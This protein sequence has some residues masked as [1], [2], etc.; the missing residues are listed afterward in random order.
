MRKVTK[1]LLTVCV[2]A[3]AAGACQD[4]II[5]PAPPAPPP[6]PPTNVVDATVSILGLALI[7]GPGSVNP[8]AVAGDI[9]VSLN[10][11]EGDNTVTAVDL[12]FNGTPVGCATINTN[13][14]PGQGVSLSTAAGADVVECFW[15]TDTFAGVCDGNN[16]PPQFANGTHT[17]GAQITLSDGTKRTASNTQQVTLVN[18]DLLTLVMLPGAQSVVSGGVTYYGGPTDVDGDGTDD[19]SVDYAVC[20]VSFAG[21]TVASL[22]LVG[23]S[24]SGNDVDLGSGPGVADLDS[25]A[26]FV[27]NVDPDDNDRASGN[28]VEDLPGLTNGHDLDTTGQILDS[29]G[30]DVS[31][32]FAS[33]SLT[34]MHHDFTSPDPTAATLT[35]AGA[36]PGALLTWYSAGDFG[37]TG[38]VEAGVGFSFGSGAVV[39]V[40]ECTDADFTDV[41]ASTSFT[42]LFANSPGVSDHTEDDWEVGGDGFAGTDGGGVDCY[43]AEL[44]SLA[45]DLG[46]AF[47]LTTLGS[48]APLQVT[49]YGYDAT[50][51]A[52]SSVMPDPADVT[53]MNP[54]AGTDDYTCVFAAGTG[55]CEVTFDQADPDLA[56]GDPGS[57]I[58]PEAAEDED[59]NALPTAGF[60][61]G[62]E[63]AVDITSLGDGPHTVTVDI[64]DLATAPNS[65]SFD[66]GLN[67]DDTAPTFG[68]LN[69]AP[70]G[71][72]TNAT[73]IVFN[74]GGTIS[75]ANIIDSAVLSVW[76]S[77]MGNAIC[78]DG[79]DVKL[80]VGTA[81]DRIDVNDVDLTDGTSAITF[82]NSFT[83]TEI[84][85]GVGTQDY[86]FLI[87]AEDEAVLIDGTDTGNSSSLSTFVTVTWN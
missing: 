69:P 44:T 49:D 41:D 50:A 61:A 32:Q 21:T 37:L 45:D 23:T 43:G 3:L 53:I 82:S 58:G 8:T 34:D 5:V 18:T 19:N 84:A 15:N 81:Q 78:G 11:E 46:N 40:V 67:L 72:S 4:N 24:A 80:T 68:A 27:W 86:C 66:I 62:D 74:I 25:A 17:L 48:T 33:A 76:I 56:S 9:N 77:D 71:S 87:A 30:L 1:R 70:A 55:E 22:S 57:G 60:G 2:A 47:D 26:P 42:P 10:V 54:S 28:P 35:L 31:G 73:S 79:G 63:I 29:S 38:V 39:D 7:P 59:G 75:D 6:P 20:P 85:G 14:V 36:G 65:H 16:L 83:V 51:P 12:L 64:E 13:A 52:E